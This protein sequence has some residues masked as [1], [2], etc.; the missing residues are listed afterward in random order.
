MYGVISQLRHT[1]FTISLTGIVL[2]LPL[3]FEGCGTTFSPTTNEP[4]TFI[5]VLPDPTRVSQTFIVLGDWGRA[6][7]HRQAEVGW[8]MG[9]AA[10]QSNVDFVITT[11]DNF[12]N[13]GVESISDP[14]W[15]ISF[16]DI[17]NHPA[18]MIPW[19]PVLG[20]HDIRGNWQ[21]QIEY[22]HISER[23]TFP[24]R[25]YTFVKEIDDTT[26]V[27]FI[28]LDSN[29]FI[30]AY[31][32]DSRYGPPLEGIDRQVQLRWLDSLLTYE[33]LNWNIVVGHHQIY[34]GSPAYGNNG[35][36]LRDLN[37]LIEK[38]GVDVYFCGHEHD[39][40]HLKPP[41]K[42]HYII[43]GAGSAVR[44]TGTGPETIFSASVSGFALVRLTAEGMNLYFIDYEGNVIHAYH[45][46]R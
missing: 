45:H 42:T 25:Y 22:S 30:N 10:A 18:L 31:Y 2:L 6:G 44:E 14:H 1:R 33:S 4:L 46:T 27:R 16:E 37:P 43:S 36:M 15:Q 11:G 24:S 40:Q 20:N 19:Y 38:H 34:S 28:M 8:Q 29:Q 32:S 39:L 9:I 7:V 5:D 3:L 26:G 12:Y 17:Y 13:D 23:W 21:A 35:D 41:G